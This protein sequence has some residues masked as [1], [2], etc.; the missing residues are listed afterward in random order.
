[1][2]LVS[3][4]LDETHDLA[5]FD[6][7]NQ[8]LDGW[9]QHH[10]R[11]AASIRQARTFVW[12][13]GDRVVLAYYALSMH[14]VRRSALPVRAGRGSP[15]VIPAVLLGR[16]ALDRRLQGQGLGGE[17]LLDAFERALAADRHAAARLMLVDAVDAR[18]V[19]FYEH[20]GFVPVPGTNRLVQ[21]MSA[22][23]RAVERRS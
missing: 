17:L 10:A 3:E 7:G 13:R 18:A 20:Y 22:L 19:A 2:E 1:M 21:K 11:H 9:L 6:C 8:T 12:H 14:L 5:P 4:A 15:D 16:L 23:A